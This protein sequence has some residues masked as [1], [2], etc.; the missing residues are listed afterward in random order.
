M[1]EQSAHAIPDVTV[2]FSFSDFRKGYLAPPFPN[3]D[4]YQI[5]CKI[6]DLDPSP[7]NGTWS[8]VSGMLVPGDWDKMIRV[9]SKTRTKYIS[10]V[11]KQ[12]FAFLS[13]VFLFL[14]L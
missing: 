8:H 14:M 4:V 11:N 1:N 13:V 5:M 12:L 2:L 9:D 10:V 6:L 7:H 3:V